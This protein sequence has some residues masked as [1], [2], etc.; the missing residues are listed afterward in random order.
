MSGLDPHLLEAMA[1]YLAA[2]LG[3]VLLHI[4]S[5]LLERRLAFAARRSFWARVYGVLVE[6]PLSWHER[7]HSGATLDRA[8]KAA[9]GLFGFV[10]GQFRWIQ[11]VMG[12]AGPVVMLTLLSWPV[13]LLAAL[14]NL[15][16]LLLVLRVDR[17]IVAAMADE[18]EAEHRFSS[19]AFDYVTHMT[20][21]LGLRLGP[22]THA[23][24]LRAHDATEPPYR[25]HVRANELKYGGISVAL[26]AL[27]V[28]ALGIFVLGDLAT[29]GSVRIGVAVAVF[30]YLNLL[31]RTFYEAAYT[32]QD[33]LRKK[34]DLSAADPLL[35]DPPTP[36]PEVPPSDW[37]VLRVEALTHRHPGAAAPCLRDLSLELK[38]GEQVAL[39]GPSGAGKSTL[40]A[41]LRGLLEPGSGRFTLDGAPARDLRGFRAGVVLVP[42]APEIFENDLL[43]NLTGG[44]EHAPADLDAA[45]HD[46]CL[47]PVVAR[48]PRGLDTDLRE[49]GVNLSGGERQRVALARALLFAREARLLLLDEATSSVDRATEAEIYR[50]V[51]ARFRGRTV[52]ASVHGL[53]LLPRF[54]R[55]LALEDGRCEE[56]PPSP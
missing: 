5:R 55:V 44:L 13:A 19:V 18:N 30:R 27:E 29:R 45:I 54:D 38:R 8:R 26:A 33:L 21:I 7:H 1:L 16:V 53:H 46:A 42:Q 40:L 49:R 6:R 25:R 22:R 35:A 11:T 51:Q 36:A 15:L 17:V 48:L 4:P 41:L 14:V 32:Y 9:D 50:R 12:L 20:T 31:G 47:E 23:E 3:F 10:G 39:V 24:L 2:A 34:T 52:V 56:R 37:G 28:V 43:F